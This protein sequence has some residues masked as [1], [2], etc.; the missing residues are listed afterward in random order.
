[1]G[2]QLADGAT[3]VHF[4]R[5]AHGL[6]ALHGAEIVPVRALGLAAGRITHGHRFQGVMDIQVATADAYEEALAAHGNVVASFGERQADI[7][8]QLAEQASAL[9]ATLGPVRVK[10]PWPGKVRRLVDARPA[11]PAKS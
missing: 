8:R 7:A 6:V 10:R 3:T 5:P 1:M 11:T 9:N 4:V 2:Y